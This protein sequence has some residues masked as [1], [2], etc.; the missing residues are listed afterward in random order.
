L[1]NVKADGSYNEHCALKNAPGVS[2]VLG[3]KV[4]KNKYDHIR[5]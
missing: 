2:I 3:R 5:N 4:N 1:F